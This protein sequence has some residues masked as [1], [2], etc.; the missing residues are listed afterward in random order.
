MPPV[1]VTSYLH[2]ELSQH[3]GWEKDVTK[4]KNR[5]KGSGKYGRAKADLPLSDRRFLTIICCHH[6]LIRSVSRKRGNTT[7]LQKEHL[8]ANL[9]LP[10]PSLLAHIFRVVLFM[11]TRITKRHANTSDMSESATYPP[12]E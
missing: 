7:A 9:S 3:H 11:Y 5:G 8:R 10:H 12:S 2:S 4:K 6:F 1:L